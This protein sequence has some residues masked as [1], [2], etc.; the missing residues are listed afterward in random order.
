MIIILVWPYRP[1]IRD[2]IARALAVREAKFAL[3]VLVRLYQGEQEKRI[4]CR[5]CRGPQRLPTS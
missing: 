3:D 4:S 2:A 5:N 1:E